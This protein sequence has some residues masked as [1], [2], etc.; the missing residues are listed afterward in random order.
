MKGKR[1]VQNIGSNSAC[2]EGTWGSREG[3][4]RERAIEKTGRKESGTFII[5]LN[6]RNSVLHLPLFLI[7][8]AK[9]TESVTVRSKD[10]SI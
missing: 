7:S 5:T 8:N 6:V 3:T 1:E 2:H 9:L 4:E 10:M